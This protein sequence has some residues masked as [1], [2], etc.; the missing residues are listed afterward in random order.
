MFSLSAVTVT[1][2]LLGAT[3]SNASPAKRFGCPKYE[4]ITARGTTL[5]QGDTSGYTDMLNKI[6]AAV[7]GGSHYDVNYPASIDFYNSL[8]AGVN[9]L[10]VHINNGITFCPNQVYALLGLSQGAQVI[11]NYLQKVN[12]TS[13]VNIYNHIKAIVLLGDPSHMPNNPSNID[14]FGGTSTNPYIGGGIGG[15]R[16]PPLPTWYSNGRLL[17]ICHNQDIICAVNQTGANL[18]NHLQYNGSSVVQNLGANFVVPKL[19]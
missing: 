1:L 7:P 9:D 15:F 16:S 12:T 6:L 17:D 18:D 4:V 14:E 11:D 2:A 10:T 3:V 5:A 19:S 8:N 13:N